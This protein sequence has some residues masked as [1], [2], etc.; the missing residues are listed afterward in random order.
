MEINKSKV[1]Q[2][3]GRDYILS[4][5]NSQESYVEES[6]RS[7]Y[8]AIPGSIHQSGLSQSAEQ[9]ILKDQKAKSRDTKQLLMHSN[10]PT[11]D[12]A[13]HPIKFLPVHNHPTL[14]TQQSEKSLRHNPRQ[15]QRGTESMPVFHPVKHLERLS[16][17]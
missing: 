9:T 2:Q 10:V 8:G 5:K 1:N 11:D 7:A 13:S 12:Q 3:S 15:K 17:E 16:D 6:K 14:P 4:T